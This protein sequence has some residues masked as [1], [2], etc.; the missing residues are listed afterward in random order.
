M[1]LFIQKC[2]HSKVECDNS[3]EEVPSSETSTLPDPGAGKGGA[4]E[5]QDQVCPTT[6]KAGVGGPPLQKL[7]QD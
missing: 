4:S 2:W 3:G 7:H 1:T 5:R 6:L